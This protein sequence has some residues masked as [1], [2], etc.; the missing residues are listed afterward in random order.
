MPP[1]RYPGTMPG[2]R[3]PLPCLLIY[4]TESGT[5]LS[6][7]RGSPDRPREYQNSRLHG[8]KKR[9]LPRTHPAFPLRESGVR[10][11]RV[12]GSHKGS[13]TVPAACA[14]WRCGPIARRDRGASAVSH[15]SHRRSDVKGPNLHRPRRASHIRHNSR[16]QTAHPIEF[17]IATETTRADVRALGRLH[18]EAPRLASAITAEPARDRSRCTHKRRFSGFPRAQLRRRAHRRVPAAPPRHLMPR[19]QLCPHLHSWPPC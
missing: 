12:P 1:Y 13:Y 7:L 10:D 19:T 9:N 11:V 3:P 15:A 5:T 18:A 2:T 4:V 6:A 17:G 8:K 16:T 14:T